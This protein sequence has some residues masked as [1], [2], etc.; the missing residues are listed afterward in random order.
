MATENLQIRITAELSQIRAAL[1]GLQGQLETAR[2]TGAQ[3][4]SA[5]AQGIAQLNQRLQ[6]TGRLV[7]GIA[8]SLGAGLSIAGLVRASDE[9]QT[10]SARLKLATGNAQQLATAQKAVF[11]LAQR[12]RTSLLATVDLYARIERSTRDLK[13]NQATILQLTETI[14]QAAQISGGGASAEAALF[15]LSQGLAAGT[16]RGEELNS[17][18]EQTPRLAQAIA[19]GMNI[20]IGKLR[21]IAQEG[22]LTSEAVLRALLSQSETLQKEFAEFPPTIASG[23]TAI[24]NAF[25]QY[26][27]TSSQAGTAARDFA[28]A[29]QAIARAL[30]AI[31]DGVVRLG[32]VVLAVYAAFKLW[33]LI[34]AAVAIAQAAVARFTAQLALMTPAMT[35]AAAQARVL[36][37][38]MVAV[39]PASALGAKGAVGAL[40]LIKGALGVLIAAFAGWQIGTYLREQFL[41]VRLFGIAMVTGLMVAWETLK[42][43]VRQIGVTIR[44][45]FVSAFNYVLDKAAAFYRA[46]GRAAEKIPGI[47]ARASAT[48][49]SFADQLTASKVEAE[50]IANAFNRVYQET[51]AAKEQARQIG[52]EMADWEI[53]EHYAKKAVE[54]AAGEI[55]IAP[56][57]TVDP[58]AAQQAAKIA[59]TNAELV[60]DAVQRALEQLNRLYDDGKVSIRDYFAEKQ[61]LELQGIDAAL[62]AARAELA[63]AKGADDVAAAQAKITMLMRD[64]KQVAVDAI[65]AQKKAEEELTRQLGALQIRLLQAQGETGRATRAQ[66]E[67][68]FRDLLVRLQAEGDTAGYNL[69]RKVINIETFKAQLDQVQ[70]KVSESLGRFNATETATGAQVEAGILGQDD[71]SRRVNQQREASLAVLV[72]QREE[73]V[74]I[75]DAAI[76][77]DDALTM[78]RASDAIVELDGNIAQLSINTESLG[79]KATQVLKSA[80][81]TFFTDLADGSKSASDALRDFV[82][83]FVRGMAQIA[84]QALATYLVLQLLDAIYPGLGKATAATMGAASNHSGGMAG[85]GGVKRQLPALLFAGA[86]RYHSGGVAGLGADEVPAVLKKGEEVLTKNDPRHRYNGGLAAEGQ[87][88]NQRF[89]FIDDERR[90][91][92]YLN[93]PDSDEVFVQKIG[94]NAGAI[95][96]LIRS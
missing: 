13:V 36:S 51:E 4:G 64:R 7:A 43:G 3:V 61:R 88:G 37:A 56:G 53:N 2:K 78:Q 20:P 54:G 96:E 75:R 89:I 85:A 9:A 18:L 5:G 58:K 38:S 25:V 95:R 26:L 29:L 39:G 86:P 40:G 63:A 55:G 74:K 30:P 69:A 70:S 35:A 48:Y 15:Q 57:S 92:D 12:T 19:D 23:F 10:I 52:D 41:E 28:E 94:R 67:E 8:A 77:A 81:T 59:A 93:A 71:A 24:R 21:E 83:N 79:Y 50:G 90:V 32:P 73:L 27:Q 66:L 1:Q 68:E 62:A 46:L 82:L 60:R 49:S 84:A 6:S 45:V 76:A 14:N 80:L 72:Q 33:P 47:G 44:E 91:E 87:R 42:G 65:Y 17:V 34:A 16:L 31:I 22:K 11:D